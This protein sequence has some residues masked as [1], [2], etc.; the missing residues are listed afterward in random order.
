[1]TLSID[2]LRDQVATYFEANG[3]DVPVIYGTE[4]D[5][6]DMDTPARVVIGLS[7]GFD[8]LP[9]GPSGAPGHRQIA[10]GYSS[11]SIGT[12]RQGFWI[13]VRAI[14]SPSVDDH[15]RVRVSQSLASDLFD[16]VFRAIH[17]VAHGPHGLNINGK[18]KWL[19]V[20]EADDRYGA[21]LRVTGTLDI[22]IDERP[23]PRFGLAGS[24][25]DPTKVNIGLDLEACDSNVCTTVVSSP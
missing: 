17:K 1:M 9:A 10:P 23:R 12:K 11:R 8:L 21:A 6:R 2:W 7:E 25:L 22:P 15:D 14:P 18:G 3:I 4:R 13:V 5:Y 24:S 20:D 16:H 19:E